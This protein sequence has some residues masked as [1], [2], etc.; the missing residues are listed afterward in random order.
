VHEKK[1]KKNSAHNNQSLRHTYN[2]LTTTTNHT[3]KKPKKKPKP[4]QNKTKT[5]NTQPRAGDDKRRQNLAQNARTLEEE[6]T[7][8][9][10]TASR[11][12]G[13]S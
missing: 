4:K 13:V 8:C 1:R 7:A 2:H 5:E 6:N 12:N 9:C 3:K 11:A 10:A